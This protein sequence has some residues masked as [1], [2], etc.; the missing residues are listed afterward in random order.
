[1]SDADASGHLL[2]TDPRQLRGDLPGPVRP[3][4][5]EQPGGEPFYHPRRDAPG[6][7][8]GLCAVARELRAKPGPRPLGARDADGPAHRLRDSVLPRLSLAGADRHLIGAAHHLPHLQSV[9]GDVDDA[10]VLRRHPALA[11]GGGGHRRRGAAPSL[12]PHHAAPAIFCFVF[13]WNDFFY[14]LVLTRSRA[15]MAPVAIVNFMN[16]E[17]WEWGKIGAAAT[18]IMLP[19]ILFALAVRRYLI[20]GLTAGALK[21]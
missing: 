10:H 14:A 16:Y 18:M 9:A 17:G 20:R 15:L 3:L 1:G 8:R 21:G 13:A 7:A 5:P 12:L 11:G 4:L 19:V 6:R 2:R